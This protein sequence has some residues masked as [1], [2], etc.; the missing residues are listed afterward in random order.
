MPNRTF[1]QNTSCSEHGS[2]SAA[3]TPTDTSLVG[4]V[5]KVFAD[6]AVY[7]QTTGNYID[8]AQVTTKINAGTK[9]GLIQ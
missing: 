8:P 2:K 9:R 1:S 4:H 7:D 6:F 3:V 5:I